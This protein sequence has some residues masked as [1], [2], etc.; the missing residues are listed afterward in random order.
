MPLKTYQ[1]MRNFKK[2][3]EPKGRIAKSTKPQSLYIIQKHAASHLHYD[4]RLELNGVLL[5][6]AVPKGPSLDPTVKRLA[7]HVEDH[8]LEYGTFEGTIPKG[9]YGGGT[10]MLWDKGKWIAEDLNPMQAYRKGSLTFQLKGE[11][12]QGRWKLIRMNNNDKTWLLMKLRDDYAKSVKKFDVTEKQPNS[13][14][15][16][17]TMDEIANHSRKVWK[18]KSKN[19]PE[20]NKKIKS[21]SAPEKI[22]LP[23]NA[24]K[25]PYPEA[26]FPELATLVDSPPAGKD[27][28]HEIKFDGYRFIAFKQGSKVRLVTRNQNDWSSK[29][30]TVI[31]ELRKF[32]VKNVILDGEIVVLDKNQKSNF[33]S[34]QN[35]I[36]DSSEEF[37]YYIFDVLYY[38]KFNLMGLK[39]IERKKILENILNNQSSSILKYSDHVVGSGKTVFAKSC[40]VGLEGIVSKK[41][42]SIYSQERNKNWLKVK[43]I[44]RQ[45]FV[46]GGFHLSKRRKYFRSLMLGTFNNKKEFLYHGNVGTGF[47]E[48]SLKNIHTELSKYITEKMPYSKRPPE[49]RD[50]IWVEPVL[51]AEIE[52]TEW[53]RDQT[54]R[55]PSFK[56]LRLDKKAK[57]I[58][59]EKALPVK[60]VAA[61]KPSKTHK[62]INKNLAV[63]NEKEITSPL[64]NPNKILYPEDKITKRD[65]LEYYK[66]V[67]KWILPYV[68]NRPLTLVRCPATYKKCF[69]QKHIDNKA[70]SALH[71]I[72]IKE[73][74]GED[75]YIYIDNLDGLLALPQLNALEIHIWGSQIKKVEY[76]DQ[77]IF[78]LDPAEGLPWKKV[79]EAAFEIK[80]VLDSYKLKSFV[81]TTGGKGLHVVI[82]IK[83]EYDWSEVKNFSKILVDYLVMNHPNKYIGT[84]NKVKRKN[85]IFIDYLRNQRGATAIAPYSIRARKG[86]PCAVPLAWDELTNNIRDT[87]YNIET[88]IKRLK[89]L[90]K[91]PWADFFKIKQSLKLDKI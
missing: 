35:A 31:Q 51:V 76:P 26:I 3:P 42:D 40:K 72:S 53:T 79:V 77:M 78:D 68:V 71:Q 14:K 16:M 15:T 75:D 87:S 20:K 67:H 69:F 27:W 36:K 64:T 25:T 10:V 29:F 24:L 59:K 12:L 30:K 57:T 81:K 23:K 61:I 21:L 56:G 5:S 43:C 49:S 18:G 1:Q 39:L 84:M 54:L 85:K 55:H 82:P 89:S 46:I 80:E 70:V 11:K 47:T 38:D 83:P 7:M 19:E 2:T 58:T 65:V 28:L 88:V 50:A 41:A 37:I 63:K 90:K 60:S 44:K 8:P 73:K 6:W 91:D 13:V 17:R 62:K 86:A 9:E 45:E 66:A 74:I 48:E 4:F 33:Q 22:L 32:P 34:L 52:F